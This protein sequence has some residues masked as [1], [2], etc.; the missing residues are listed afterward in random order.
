MKVPIMNS[1][2]SIVIPNWNGANLLKKYLP[3]VIAAAGNSEVIVADDAS[4]DDSC[5]I[6]KEHFP[7]VR[8]IECHRHLGYSSTVNAGVKEASSEIVVLLNT[9]IEPN[10]DFL[11]PLVSHFKDPNVFAVGCMDKSMEKGNIIRRGRGIAFW[12]NGFYQ[13]ARGETNQTNTAWVSGGSGA[14]RKSMWQKLGGMDE[15]YNPYY[16]ED[17]DLSYRAQKL[18]W[19]VRFEARSVVVHEHEEGKIKSTVSQK[20][21]KMVSFRNQCYFIWKN[22]SD[23]ALIFSHIVKLP[24]VILRALLSGDFSIFFGFILALGLLPYAIRYRVSHNR[25]SNRT[26]RE[27][28][29]IR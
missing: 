27:I 12:Q 1:S 16:W 21:V 5:R 25:A 2:V 3:S 11:G 14:F 20:Q 13:H 23:N 22:I 18:G 29:E 19:V 6:L 4:T 28:I 24:V 26:D 7:S 10:R 15:S 8:I 17:I 9:D